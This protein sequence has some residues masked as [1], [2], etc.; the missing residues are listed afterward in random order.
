MSIAAM[1]SLALYL[2]QATLVP[3]LTY[4]ET[5]FNK[6]LDVLYVPVYMQGH[7]ILKCV[8]A[9]VYVTF[10]GYE[11]RTRLAML[12]VVNVLMLLLQVYIQPCSIRSINVM[13]TAIFTSSTWAAL[14]STLYVSFAECASFSF[15]VMVMV[16]GWG[17]IY[18]GSFL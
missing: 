9:S 16:S 10:Y 5:M 11:E 13:R 17:M 8:F 3:T 12:L 7:W 14:S 2:T 6:Q 15:L 4:K 18:G 1:I